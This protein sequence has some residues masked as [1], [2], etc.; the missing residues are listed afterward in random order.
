MK[1]AKVFYN[2]PGFL[3]ILYQIYL[4][5]TNGKSTVYLRTPI[6]WFPAIK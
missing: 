3:K 4:V 6:R 2:M 5:K 1:I